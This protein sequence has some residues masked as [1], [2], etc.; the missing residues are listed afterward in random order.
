MSA[1]ISYT[2]LKCSKRC[3]WIFQTFF[4]AINLLKNNGTI[5]N[6]GLKYP[7][8]LLFKKKKFF[9]SKKIYIDYLNRSSYVGNIF[10]SIR[11][12]S[13]IE[14]LSRVLYIFI[15][16]FYNKLQMSMYKKVLFSKELS[17]IYILEIIYHLFYLQLVLLNTLCPVLHDK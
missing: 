11:F 10:R 8:N 13:I 17:M 12:F 3:Y 7:N 16:F 2:N 9:L 5:Q 1:F 15:V 14:V 4:L 6:L